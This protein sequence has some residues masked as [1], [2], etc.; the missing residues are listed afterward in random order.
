MSALCPCGSGHPFSACC[1]PFLAGD[2]VPP[3][4]EALMRSRYSAFVARDWDY[5]NRT[6]ANRDDGPPTPDIEWLGLDVLA[7]H[8][9]T[10]GEHEG[11]VEFVARYSHQGRPAALHEISR[12]GLRD[13]NWIYLDGVFPVDRPLPN[14]LPPA[15]E[16]TTVVSRR[17]TTV[18]LG[19]NEPCPCG[20]GKKFKKCCGNG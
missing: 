17:E 19:R 13:G 6:Q 15:G 1:G 3:S 2:A 9:G 7:T 16:G 8:G 14:P 20:S 11:T 18:K 4:A 5:L 12:F 10:A